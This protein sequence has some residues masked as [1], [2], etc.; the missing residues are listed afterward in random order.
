[1][2]IYTKKEDKRSSY[3]ISIIVIILFFCLGSFFYGK[4]SQSLKFSD[5]FYDAFSSTGVLVLLGIIFE[6][7]ALFILFY[8]LK[9][10]KK[11]VFKLVDKKMEI[12]KNKE[13]TYMTFVISKLNDY[14]SDYSG[15]D[16]YKC[17]TIG[18]NNFC[19][20][21]EYLLSINQIVWVPINIE[22]YQ[23]DIIKPV[24]SKTLKHLLLI[25]LYLTCLFLTL[26]FGSSIMGVFVDSVNSKTLFSGLLYGAALIIVV[27]LIKNFN[28]TDQETNCK[29][30]IVNDSTST[31][32]NNYNNVGNINTNTTIGNINTNFTGNSISSIN[33]NF[34]SNSSLSEKELKEDLE[35][36]VRL[37]KKLEK[38]SSFSG[39]QWRIGNTKIKLLLKY[40]LFIMI[41]G[42]IF[43]FVFLP[44]TISN[45]K[46]IFL[47][48]LFLASPLIL[49]L[50]FSIGY[51]KRLLREHKINISEDVN[52][53]VIRNFSVLDANK[54]EKIA[55]YFGLDPYNNLIFKIKKGT[56]LRT[57]YIICDKNNF[58][59]GEIRL[60][61]FSLRDEFIVR[62]L[63]EKPFIIKS[64]FQGNIAYRIYGRN[65]FVKGD[66]YSSS[67]T[68]VDEMNN[69]IA[70]V[71]SAYRK[72]DVLYDS[73]RTIVRLNS[74]ISSID[75]IVIAFCLRLCYF[76]HKFKVF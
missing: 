38:I 24:K 23:M 18:E 51:D 47:I 6:V 35:E 41:I 8:L 54:K 32:D 25:P 68:I 10:P 15:F 4:F 55:Q 43:Y 61:M 59:I 37:E 50:I 30:N 48:T 71:D 28:D 20:E 40:I 3:I 58:K 46:V 63:N 69:I 27:K 52:L 29:I 66:Y 19:L 34:T 14:N 13:I 76:R 44:Q 7:V 53:N 42:L 33:N 12:Y 26:Q 36:D 22:E 5:S 70:Y 2:K 60:K 74:Y 1:M 73:P 75:I 72:D 31:F 67:N 21:Q 57:K 9:S 49:M 64:K 11:N 45:L 56:G 16:E 65:Y 17:Y 39:I 62:I